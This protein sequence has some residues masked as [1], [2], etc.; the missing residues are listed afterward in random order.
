MIHIVIPVHNRLALTKRCI[1]SLQ[2]QSYKDFHVYIVDDGSSD[3]TFDWVSS[4]KQK[5]ISC[6]KGNG[7]LW[8]TGSMHLGVRHVLENASSD[9]Y[10]MSLNND[11]V[12][13]EDSIE[14]LLISVKNT[15][16]IASSL[17]ISNSEDKRIMSSGAKMISWIF[18]IAH[19][20]F[21]GKLYENLNTLKPVQ[22]D[23]LTGRSVLYP[24]AVFDKGNSF[25]YERFPQYGGDNEFTHRAKKLGY[26]L[27]IIPASVV[28]V[29]REETGL[30]PMDKILSLSEKIKSLYS[31]R[32]VNNI[33]V[34]SR[35][36]LMVPPFYARPTYLVISILKIFIQLLFSN[37]YIKFRK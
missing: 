5:N 37:L 29:Q 28:F 27:L 9:D 4:Q 12:L 3:G 34:R 1:D 2:A 30:N 20:P 25:D 35:F 24:I 8:W 11:V 10:L 26:K 18:N 6:I 23:M 13:A 14:V 31:I 19:H 21:Y 7:S 22:V 15:K 36:A 16:S 32:S 33:I 17:S